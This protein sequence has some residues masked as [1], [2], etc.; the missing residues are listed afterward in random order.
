MAFKVK[1]SEVRFSDAMDVDNTDEDRWEIGEHGTLTI[2]R[3]DGTSTTYAAH[4]W[5]LVEER[6]AR[7][8]SP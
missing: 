8:V 7:E 4:A 1:F 2:H 5:D 3:A 6:R